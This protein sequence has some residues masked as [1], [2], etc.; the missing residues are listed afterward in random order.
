MDARLI[1]DAYLG[2]N[3]LLETP[4]VPED[5]IQHFVED[6]P[7]VWACLGYVR[8]VP[9]PQLKKGSGESLYP[10]FM[11]ETP[12]S[13]WEIVD[14]K[15]PSQSIVKKKPNRDSFYAPIH[16]GLAQLDEYSEYF[17]DS[18]HRKWFREK[19]GIEIGYRPRQLLIVGGNRESTSG[20]DDGPKR[21]RLLEKRGR[22]NILTYDDILNR[23][24][25]EQAS[26]VGV[27][28][29]ARAMTWTIELRIRQLTPGRPNYLIDHLSPAGDSWSIF[30][31]S[32][33]QLTLQVLDTSGDEFSTK[34]TAQFPFGSPATLSFLFASS[35]QNAVLQ[36]AVNGVTVCLHRWPNRITMSQPLGGQ[37]DAGRT[38]M[39]NSA[40]GGEGTAM[41]FYAS[42]A[43][44]R[45]LSF[46]E[47]LELNAEW[48]PT[49]PGANKV[50]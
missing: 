45:P 22:T 32:K 43:W 16:D 39:G 18:A 17:S 2:L 5:S 34:A 29:L 38:V 20:D 48:E 3:A 10:D 36:I 8:A 44:A 49:E 41:E 50:P 12:E 15:L 19:H 26:A 11:V 23:L 13:T 40:R 28:P 9:K 24:V 25:V 30:F 42:A 1:E 14:L 46:L 47:L 7:A 35:N 4:H 21:E 33:G 37:L 27:E 6:H 31:D